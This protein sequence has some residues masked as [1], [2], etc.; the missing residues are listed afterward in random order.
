[1]KLKIEKAKPTRNQ[2][3]YLCIYWDL[4]VFFLFVFLFLFVVVVFLFSFFSCIFLFAFHLNDSFF[5]YLFIHSF[6]HPFILI[7]IF[8]SLQIEFFRMLFDFHARSSVWDALVWCV[9]IKARM[10]FMYK[11]ISKNH[12]QLYALSRY[13]GGR[14]CWCW[15]WCWCYCCVGNF[16]WILF[17]LCVGIYRVDIIFGLLA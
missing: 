1:M 3:Q 13:L 11:W 17:S 9:R 2:R 15:C 4:S 16:H 6:N 8:Y 5:I 12:I 10:W 14:P 7:F